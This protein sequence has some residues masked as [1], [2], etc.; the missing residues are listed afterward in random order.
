MAA[1]QLLGKEARR[2]RH[3]LFR[4]P[5]SE[6][7]HLYGADGRSEILYEA[8]KLTDV[9]GSSVWSCRL[10]LVSPQL[11]YIFVITFIGSVQ[12]FQRIYLTTRCHGTYVPMLKCL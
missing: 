8:A 1:N 9:P 11:K 12:D 3:H 2:S 7:Y 5:R 6:L 4:I 10:P